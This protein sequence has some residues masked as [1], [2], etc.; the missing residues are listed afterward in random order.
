M[1]ADSV[2]AR[3]VRKLLLGMGILG[4]AAAVASLYFRS[5]SITAG[6]AAGAAMVW[7]NLLG[8]AWLIGRFLESRDRGQGGGVYLALYILKFF[9]IIGVVFLLIT[10][11][12]INPIAFAAGVSVLLVVL[13][14]FAVVKGLDMTGGR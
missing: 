3:T 9:A 4:A 5:T 2:L 14:G 13:F 12:R 7:L 6:V 1:P 11:G 8:L 10:S